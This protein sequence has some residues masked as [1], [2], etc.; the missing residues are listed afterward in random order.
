VYILLFR[1]FPN[2]LRDQ[3]ALY[4]SDFTLCGKHRIQLVLSLL[5]SCILP[6]TPLPSCTSRTSLWAQYT[7]FH[8]HTIFSHTVNII[9]SLQQCSHGLLLSSAWSPSKR[10]L[11]QIQTP[12][13]HKHDSRAL[14]RTR[15]GLMVH[16]CVRRSDFLSQMDGLTLNGHGDCAGMS[17]IPGVCTQRSTKLS[18]AIALE[19]W[20]V[21]PVG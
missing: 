18:A 5:S 1:P 11:Y 10:S 13:H 12:R 7:I 6:G 17:I 15:I 20:S 21:Q 9:D 2:R 8:I 16:N 14:W 19:F 4:G 3:F